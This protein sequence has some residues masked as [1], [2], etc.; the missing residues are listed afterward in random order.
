MLTESSIVGILTV[1]FYL[2]DYQNMKQNLF[3]LSCKI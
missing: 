3:N 2:Y 1:D